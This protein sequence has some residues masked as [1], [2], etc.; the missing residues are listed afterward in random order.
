VLSVALNASGVCLPTCTMH[1]LTDH[2]FFRFVSHAFTRSGVC[3]RARASSNLVRSGDVETARRWLGDL[4]QAGEQCS[5]SDVQ[6]VSASS[7]DECAALVRFLK[8]EDVE[9]TELASTAISLLAGQGMWSGTPT[10]QCP[11]ARPSY[12]NNCAL[13]GGQSR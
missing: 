9:L 12:P 3:V 1:S 10:Q 13:V 8:T 6:S 2:H 4:V 5:C 11:A 7:P